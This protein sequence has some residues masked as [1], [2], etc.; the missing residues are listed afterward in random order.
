[1]RN[2][3]HAARHSHAQRQC[4]RKLGI[5]NHRAGQDAWIF[6]SALETAFGQAIDGRYFRS[7][8]SRGDGY[9]RQARIQCNRLAQSRGRT[10]ANGHRAIRTQPFRFG[11][12]LP[13]S[14]DGDMH[15]GFGKDT[16]RILAE[17]VRYPVRI[18]GL[19]GR[20]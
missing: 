7:R 10:T 9:N 15:Y 13:R 12:R 19:F 8:V 6:P 11:A 3:V 4:Q 17:V 18:R 14:L 20:R 2:C 5:V 16:R 1:M